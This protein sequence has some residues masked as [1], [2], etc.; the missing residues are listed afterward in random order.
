[1]W[2]YCMKEIH[3]ILIHFS[4]QMK[5]RLRP[6]D[7]LKFHHFQS[8]TWSPPIVSGQLTL[9]TCT[10][11][12]CCRMETLNDS[13]PPESRKRWM[14]ILTR[15]LKRYNRNHFFSYLAVEKLFKF[16]FLWA[17]KNEEEN[18]Y[19]ADVTDT[20]VGCQIDKMD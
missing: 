3:L 1:M 20:Q 9:R 10:A 6:V 12:V 14:W 13:I 5:K 4:K 18:V 15:S 11:A 8:K 19:T 17:L 2:I 7:Q 16:F